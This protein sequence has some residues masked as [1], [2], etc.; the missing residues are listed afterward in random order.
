MTTTTAIDEKLQSRLDFIGLDDAAR[1]RQSKL[2]KHVDRHIAIALDRFYAKVAVVPEVARFFTGKPHMDKAQAGQVGHWKTVAEA[3]FDND[4]LASSSRVG[5]VHARIGLEP[6]WHIGGYGIIA[7]TLIVGLVH[8]LMEE[9]LAPRPRR[10]GTRAPSRREI[11]A[12]ADDMALALGSLVKSTL[13]DIDI[14][15]TAYF[16][17]LSEVTKA[18]EAA[19]QGRIIH[20]MGETGAVLRQVAKGDLTQRITAD[21]APE[22]AGIKDDTNAVADRL[23]AMIGQLRQTT[24]ALQTATAEILSGANDL[25]ERTT[26]QAATIEETAA[27]VEQLTVAVVENAQRALAASEKAQDLATNAR[28]GGAVMQQ[29]N[30]AMEAIEASSTRISDVVG[31]IDDIAFQTNLLALNASVEAAR[32]GDTGKGFAVVAVEVRRLAQSAATASRDIKR[33]I[34]TST[35][36]VESGTSLVAQASERLRS[37]LSG[38][39]DSA[40]L[41][42]TIAHANNEQANA[43]EEVAAAVRVMDGMTQHN[44]ALVEQTHAAV[45]QSERQARDLDTMVDRFSISERAVP[46]ESGELDVIMGSRQRLKAG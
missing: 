11:M 42:D 37:I 17:R 1:E 7:E 12:S 26:K 46:R 2:Q 10:F 33:L 23:S 24:G 9:A 31:L 40:A 44:A 43:L 39:Q 22:F 25:N 38:A 5:L 4:Y 20:A 21:F 16:D 18:E 41:I 6:R 3:R 34:E 45:E 29:A 15:L 30:V 27:S 8:D 19:V 36:A 13:L 35:Q 14:G 32:A 28:E